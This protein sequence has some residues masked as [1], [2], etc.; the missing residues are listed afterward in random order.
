M[1]TPERPQRR[2]YRLAKPDQ[3]DSPTGVPHLFKAAAANTAGRFDFITAS[4]APMTGPPLHLHLEQHD[5]LYILEGVLTVQVGD[6]IF[7]IGTG[8]FI[9]V[10]PHVPHTFDNLHNGDQP[11]RAINL[12]TPG[13][14]FEMFEEMAAVGAGPGLPEAIADAAARHGTIILGPPLRAAFGLR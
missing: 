5:T 2:A 6:D 8:D 11:V 7:D 12:M 10:P 9:T 13:G 14:H 4:F 3:G 1:T